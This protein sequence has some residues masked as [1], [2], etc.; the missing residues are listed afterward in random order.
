MSNLKDAIKTLTT[1]GTKKRYWPSKNPIDDPAD[2]PGEKNYEEEA[3]ITD[4]VHMNKFQV[5]AITDA[6]DSH[7]RSAENHSPGGAWLIWLK[8]VLDHSNKQSID[9]KEFL[10]LLKH[11]RL[12]TSTRP[13][14]KDLDVTEL[15]DKTIGDAGGKELYADGIG[16]YGKMQ[17]EEEDEYGRDQGAMNDHDSNYDDDDEEHMHDICQD[18]GG[19]GCKHC[20]YSGEVGQWIK[21]RPGEENEEEDCQRCGNTGYTMDNGQPCPECG[22]GKAEKYAGMGM[23]DDDKQYWSV[24]SNKESEEN[25]EEHKDCHQCGNTGLD[26]GTN[27]PCESCPEGD[28]FKK[29]P[30]KTFKQMF[31]NK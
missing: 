25:E 17:G 19:E 20:N 6:L 18:C 12:D 16:A 14:F 23:P 27:K 13:D 3:E 24:G 15:L 30:A 11:P 9:R 21:R 8:N 26:L 5:S 7:I 4:D 31:P 22:Q 10:E 2:F 28:Q 1:E 29:G